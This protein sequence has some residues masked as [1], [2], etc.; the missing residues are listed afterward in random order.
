MRADAAADSEVHVPS[1]WAIV[2]AGG[3]D[4][5]LRPLVRRV[6][7]DERPK[8]YATLLGSAS[9]LRRTLERVARAILPERTVVVTAWGHAG[10]IAHEFAGSLV[11]RVLVQPEDRGTAAGVLWPAHWIHCHEPDAVVVVFPVRP[12]CLG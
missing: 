1:P 9:L 10:Y 2:L 3:E 5:R 12:F 4:M 11:P 7:G 8:Q 6:C